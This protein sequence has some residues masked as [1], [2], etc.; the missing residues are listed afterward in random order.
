MSEKPFKVPEIDMERVRIKAALPVKLAE[1]S[2]INEDATI[3]ILQ[4]WG[5]LEI[6]SDGLY[7]LWEELQ[8]EIV[9]L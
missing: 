3:R 8:E 6:Y 2:R 1:L 7:E 4:K 9:N 5:G